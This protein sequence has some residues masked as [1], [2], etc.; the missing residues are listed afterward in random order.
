[1][2][3]FKLAKQIENLIPDDSMLVRAWPKIGRKVSIFTEPEGAQVYW[4]KYGSENNNLDLKSQKKELIL[5][6]FSK[7]VIHS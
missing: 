4:K 1:M 7:K 2:D 6:S 3:A 5:K